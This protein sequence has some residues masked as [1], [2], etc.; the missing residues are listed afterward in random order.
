MEQD[1]LTFRDVDEVL[2]VLREAEA[3]GVPAGVT[4]L[5]GFT[6]ALDVFK[7]RHAT[8]GFDESP[9]LAVMPPFMLLANKQGDL[10]IGDRIYNVSTAEGADEVSAMLADFTRRYQDANGY[11]YNET[12]ESWRRFWG[13]FQCFAALQWAGYPTRYFDDSLLSGKTGY[14]VVIQLWKGRCPKFLRFANYPGG[15]GAEVG[16]YYRRNQ[17]FKDYAF[18]PLWR[19]QWWPFRSGHDFN[20]QFTLAFPDGEETLFSTELETT[21][22]L[23][24]WMEE[25]SYKQYAKDHG[26]SLPA[27]DEYRLDYEIDGHR[28][29]RW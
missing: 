27:P 6:S 21:W 19:W 2:Q 23:N 25:D 9:S 1:Y 15:I 5:Q 7:D 26:G 3:A 13:Q 8:S 29:D 28:Y 10:K 16:V 24:K 4:K 14:D 22:W 12:T 11:W 18:D 20:I 17:F